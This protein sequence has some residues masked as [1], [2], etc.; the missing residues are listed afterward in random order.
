MSDM[1]PMMTAV[2]KV[3]TRNPDAEF[4]VVAAK[5]AQHGK[6]FPIVFGRAK[7][8]LGLVKTKPRKDRVAKRPV[9]TKRARPS[10]ALAA[11]QARAARAHVT[12]H[13][14]AATNGDPDGL[15]GRL[16]ALLAER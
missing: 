10:D 12:S 3:L 14:K 8:L 15:V 16:G 9:A 7:A 4:K 11:A 5:V 13:A 1:N 6:L 2:C